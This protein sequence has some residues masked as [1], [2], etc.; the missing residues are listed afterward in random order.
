MVRGPA[1]RVSNNGRHH[2][3]VRAEQLNTTRHGTIVTPSRSTIGTTI[4]PT[5][6]LQYH[7]D[8]TS[9]S[10]L[11]LPP[12]P[13]NP[14]HIKSSRNEKIKPAQTPNL[15]HL[16]G[17]DNR[18]S[19][20]RRK[21]QPDGQYDPQ[22]IRTNNPKA[23]GELIQGMGILGGDCHLDMLNSREYMEDASTG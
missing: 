3:D 1:S 20:Q 16:Q 10:P 22:S 4:P 2:D 14:N 5:I 21:G 7:A 8:E 6:E 23:K 12:H 17:Y 11:P 19:S 9:R 18:G 13:A 15:H